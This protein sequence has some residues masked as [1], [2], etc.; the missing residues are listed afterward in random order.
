MAEALDPDG[1][2]ALP[3]DA[4][5]FDR[6]DCPARLR[7]YLSRGR[8]AEQ[9]ARWYRAFPAEQILLLESLELRS[10]TGTTRVLGFLGLAGPAPGGVADRNLGGYPEPAPRILARLREYFRPHNSALFDLLGRRFDW[11]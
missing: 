11:S 1:D 10:G 3:S 5:W 6:P 8:Y 9:L 4:A 2:E 7:G